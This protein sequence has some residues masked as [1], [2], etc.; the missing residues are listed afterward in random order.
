MTPLERDLGNR[1]GVKHK[2]WLLDAFELYEMAG[3]GAPQAAIAV[4]SVLFHSMTAMLASADNPDMDEF[5]KV[6]KREILHLRS[7]KDDRQKDDH[8]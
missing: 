4:T 7:A 6:M 2:Q 1:I 3:L 8:V 5:L